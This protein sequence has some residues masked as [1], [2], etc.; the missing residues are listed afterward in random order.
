MANNPQILLVNQLWQ[1]ILT[2]RT[3]YNSI[4]IERDN[5]RH[6]NRTLNHRE[7]EATIPNP[8]A[9]PHLVRNK[10]LQQLLRIWSMTRVVCI[11]IC[12]KTL[13]TASLMLIP[14]HS[15]FCF[16]T[17]MIIRLSKPCQKIN[18]M[19]LLISFQKILSWRATS[20]FTIYTQEGR[21]ANNNSNSMVTRVISTHQFMNSLY[22]VRTTLRTSLVVCK[23]IIRSL[24]R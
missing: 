1:A 16:T 2:S 5:P 9:D 7:V 11:L 6:S 17:R 18:W 12:R 24:T 23:E 10:Q 22:R 15:Q 19:N 13:L 3:C 4:V 21:A 8:S 14:K 20:N